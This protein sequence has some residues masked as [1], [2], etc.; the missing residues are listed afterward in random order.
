MAERKIWLSNVWVI[1]NDSGICCFEQNFKELNTNSD[2]I[3]GFLYA[4]MNFG[5]EV[6]DK[7]INTI[8]FD[9]LNFCFKIREKYVMTIAVTDDAKDQDVQLFLSQLIDIFDKDYLK[10]LDDWDM[11]VT[12][13]DSFGNNVEELASME[14]KHEYFLKSKALKLLSNEHEK[15]KDIIQAGHQKFL[16]LVNTTKKDINT[17]KDDLVATKDNL[18]KQTE[19]KKEEIF[20]KLSEIKGKIV[21]RFSN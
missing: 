14:S 3:T 11:I 10:F 6:A 9:N 12:H 2:L 13:F 18:I 19:Q 17:T 21:K 4:M 5:K 1:I 20:E 8:K 16:E 7:D 15:Y